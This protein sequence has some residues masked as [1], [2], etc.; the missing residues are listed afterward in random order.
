MLSLRSFREDVT[1]REFD[2]LGSLDVERRLTNVILRPTGLKKFAE[3]FYFVR[4][5]FYKLNFM[6]GSRCPPHEQFW[7]GLALNLLE[8]LGGREGP[9]HNQLYRDFLT[10]VGLGDEQQLRE[11]PF[12]QGF[13]RE[14]QMYCANAPLVHALAAI[15]I[16]EILDNTDYAMLLRVI[17]AAG[18]TGVGARFFRVHAEAEHFEMFEDILSRFSEGKEGASTLQEANQFVIGRQRNMWEGLL[19]HLEQLDCGQL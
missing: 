2:V 18:I 3:A 4:Y 5:D 14:W 13:N 19:S 16:Y 9:T 11:P 6:V 12:A 1:K 8:E 10:T 15:A 7:K 17:R